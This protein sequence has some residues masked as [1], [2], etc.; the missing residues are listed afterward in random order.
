MT[1]IKCLLSFKK[2][3]VTQR[4]YFAQGVKDGIYGN[5]TTFAT[6]PMTEAAFE[7]LITNYVATRGTLDNGG[8][9]QRPA[10]EMAIK[11]L[12]DALVTTANYVDTVANG[13]A[14]IIILAG[15]TPSK[16]N[17]S[18][19]AKPVKIE[20]VTLVRSEV[21]GTLVADCAKQEGV[22]S[23]VCV[24]TQSQPLPPQIVILTTGQVVIT[25]VPTPPTPAPTGP[26]P[27]KS[28]GVYVD[29]NQNRKKTFAGLVPLQTYY[30]VYFG[31]NAGGVGPLSDPVS[32][33]CL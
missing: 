2:L 1:L 6:P 20:G 9:A 18:S 26:E 3:K 33:I 21:S 29:L 15:Y 17:S 30:C 23:Y 16:G 13:D 7:L 5:A 12:L 24:L 10:W 8:S 32:V 22:N 14:N 27:T 31:I 19:V 11:S 4:P 25:E 28:M